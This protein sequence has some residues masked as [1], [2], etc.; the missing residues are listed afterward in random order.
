M[1]AFGF[2]GTA[3]LLEN[4]RIELPIRKN[5]KICLQV[6]SQFRMTNRMPMLLHLV[7]QKIL[8]LKNRPGCKCK[9]F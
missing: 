6:L 3:Y 4:R 9:G 2:N 8:V 1:E 7:T 5:E